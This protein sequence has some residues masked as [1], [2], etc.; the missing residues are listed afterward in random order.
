[1]GKEFT[2]YAM[3]FDG[4]Q[5]ENALVYLALAN[6]LIREINPN[7]ITIA[8]DMSGMPGMGLPVGE[9]GVGF[10]YR[11]AMGVPDFWIRNLKTKRL[12]SPCRH[13]P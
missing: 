7:A 1:M 13:N 4:A 3:Y 11:L 2:N 6:Q 10:D 12:P 5:D 8:E 9:G